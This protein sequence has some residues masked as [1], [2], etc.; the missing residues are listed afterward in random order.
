MLYEKPPPLAWKKYLFRPFTIKF[1][2]CF[3]VMMTGGHDMNPLHVSA[4]IVDKQRTSLPY[5]RTSSP[6]SA[7]PLSYRRRFAEIRSHSGWHIYVS[8]DIRVCALPGPHTDI[9]PC[10]RWE[11][12]SALWFEWSFIS[13][14][15][16][17]RWTIWVSKT[18]DIRLR[19]E[20]L[21]TGL[22]GDTPGHPCE[23]VDQPGRDRLE[24]ID[25][26]S[27]I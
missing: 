2:F 9:T 3:R 21:K 7:D 12:F 10:R 1:P 24:G 11:Y 25:R 13:R 22:W 27:G 14:K 23:R 19:W 17:Y 15:R 8:L 20:Q 26:L 5:T 6:D 16:P 4:N 18:H